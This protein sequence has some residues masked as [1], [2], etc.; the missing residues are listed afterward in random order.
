MASDDRIFHLF[1]C[2]IAVAGAS[3]SI[4]CDL[5][6]GAYYQIPLAL[7]PLLTEHIGRTVGEI[8]AGFPPED[9]ATIDAALAMLVERELGFWLEGD[10]AAFPPIDLHHDRPET[11]NNAIIDVAAHS[12]HDYPAL[13]AQLDELGCVHVELRCYHPIELDALDRLL[14]PSL[15]GR[16]R[17]I[18]LVVPYAG[19]ADDDV[20]RLCTRHARIA[21]LSFHGAPARRTLKLGR[22]WA[23]YWFT[24]RIESAD[25]C[26]RIHPGYFSPNLATFSEAQQFNTCL[27]GK[28][29]IDVDGEIKNCPSCT[30]CFGDAATTPLRDVVQLDRFRH[31]GKVQRDQVEVC[32]DC[33]Y[34]YICTDCRAFRSDPEN[35]LSKPA[36]CSYDPYSGV[37]G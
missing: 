22:Q 16:L 20:E 35:P 14:E 8:K 36:K 26:G 2:N 1:A 11:I 6:R 17:S 25:A 7:Y 32:R 30:E 10:A 3:R 31:L 9:A 28:V 21:S 15:R 5:Q 34:R 23:V 18:Q 13:F 29:G 19:W 24:E 4:I 37:W 12:R 27:S 33:E